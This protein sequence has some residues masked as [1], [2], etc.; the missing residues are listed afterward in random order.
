ML[1]SNR[2]EDENCHMFMVIM[3][4]EYFRCNSLSNEVRKQF[5]QSIH[6]FLV[7]RYVKRTDFYA[8]LNYQGYSH[9]LCHTLE[10][11]KV[12]VRVLYSS[13]TQLSTL[14]SILRLV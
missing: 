6:G 10:I 4:I 8:L 5:T 9:Q 3:H 12:L 13:L 1:K 14:F 2:Y 7:A 11:T